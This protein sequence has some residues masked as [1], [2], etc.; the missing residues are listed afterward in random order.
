MSADGGSRAVLAAL[1]ANTGIAVTKFIAFL[2]TGISSMLAEAIHSVADSGN[3]LL[4]LLGAN[5]AI[6]QKEALIAR[7]QPV[8]VEL[9]PVDPRSLMQG[10]FMR[11]NFRMPPEVLAGA[12]RLLDKKRPLVVARRD[13]RGVLTPLRLDRGE[14]LGADELR[15]ELTPAGGGWVFVSDA[16]SFAEGEGARW[17]AA[18]YG[19]FRVDSNGRALLVGLRGAHLE[20][21]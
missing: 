2:L 18:R 14:P 10:D 16:W 8:F 12:G 7:G 6:W 21:L 15:I 20:N 5:L 9:A 1:A 3:Q 11:L 19:E 4:L 17:A 13:P